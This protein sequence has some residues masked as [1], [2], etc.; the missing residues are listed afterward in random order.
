M[1][2]P[3]EA[4]AFTLVVVARAQ[5]A[6]WMLQYGAVILSFMSAIHWS[7]AMTRLPIGRG[8]LV[9][10]TSVMPAILAWFV[11]ATSADCG[12]TWSPTP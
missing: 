5:A 12:A 9:Y 6:R 7:A 4:L 1:L 10:G 8:A 11:T 2:I 3:H